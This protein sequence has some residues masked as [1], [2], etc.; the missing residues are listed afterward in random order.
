LRLLGDEA[1]NYLTMTSVLMPVLIG[2]A[3][4]GTDIG[5]WLYSHQTMQ[6][7][8][9]SGAVSAATAYAVSNANNLT[10][11]AS[12]VTSYYGFANGVNGATVTVNRPPTSG[13]HQSSSNAVEVI[14]QQPQQRFLSVMWGS[15]QVNVTARSVAMASGGLA[16]VLAL[17]GTAAGAIT[18]QGNTSIAL[19]S[20]SLFSDSSSSSSIAAGGSAAVS[21]YSVGTVGNVS[22]SASMTTTMGVTT[23]DP[24]LPDPYAGV[25]MPSFS[26]CD[27][28]NYTAKTTVTLSPG[29][30]CGGIG[31]NSSA[32]VTLNPGIYYLDQGNLS[33]NGGAVLTGDGV[34]LVFTSSKGNNYATA[35]ING[36]AT[37]NLTAP[38]TGPMAGI[39]LFGDRSAPLGTTYKLNGGSA[40]VFNGAVYLPEG[41]TEYT[42]G[43]NTSGPACTQLVSDTITFTGNSN[44][45]IDCGSRG[46]KPIGSMTGRL[47]E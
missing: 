27:Q 33:V 10:T 16:C 39:V 34:T 9:D 35:T 45:A 20:C 5:L 4:V 38:T 24:A 42:G 18:A 12:A 1:G 6:S 17:D 22:G 37:V 25:T 29:V 2:F 8:A 21:A 40:Q 26:G 46:T 7:A 3:G 44:F 14:I 36:G 43:T 28:H 11:Q 41:A 47:V 15:G 30:Y 23:G 13:S 31:L 19:N 32:N